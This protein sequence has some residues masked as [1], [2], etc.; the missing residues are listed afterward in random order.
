L[1]ITSTVVVAPDHLSAKMGAESVVLAIEPAIYYGLD[2]MGA[3]VWEW[4]QSPVAVIEL[5]DRIV[6]TYD[7]DAA[8]CERD[9]LIFLDDLRS[10][11]LIE[12]SDA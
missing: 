9:L 6:A 7:V 8:T 1:D 3:V 10:R 12:V 2:E 4:L 5:R 11:G